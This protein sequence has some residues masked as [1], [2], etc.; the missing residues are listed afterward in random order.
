LI[1]SRAPITP[2]STFPFPSSRMI[3]WFV[4]PMDQRLA[5]GK[6]I[7]FSSWEKINSCNRKL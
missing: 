4:P 5:Y 1:D 7:E 6:Y 2:R 3:D